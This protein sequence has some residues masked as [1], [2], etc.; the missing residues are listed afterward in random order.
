MNAVDRFVRFK[1]AKGPRAVEQALRYVVMNA[2]RNVPYYQKLWDSSGVI[3]SGIRSLADLPKLPVTSREGLLRAEGQGFLNR[4]ADPGRLFRSSTSGST[5]EPVTVFLNK[6][7]VYF[8]RASLLAALGRNVRLRFPL[9]LVDVGAMRSMGGRD[10]VQSLRIVRVVRLR[11]TMPLQEQA[12]LIRKQRPLVVQGRPSAL[13]L[14]AEELD[15]QGGNPVKPALVVTGAEVLHEPVRA[16]LERS[17]ACRVADYYGSEEIGNIA[18][19]CP[20]N[21]DIMHVNHDTCIVEVVDPHGAPLPTGAEGRVLATNLYNCTMPFIRYDLG[22]QAA[23]VQDRK[24]CRC[25]YSGTSMKLLSGRDD[26]F[27]VLPDGRLASPRFVFQVVWDALPVA[28]LGVRLI[29]SV[30][31]LQI[32]QETVDHMVVRVVPGEE[33]RPELWHSLDDCVRNL[34]PQMN[35][36]VQLVGEPQADRSGKVRQIVSHVTKERPPLGGTKRTTEE[37]KLRGRWTRFR[38]GKSP[39]DV[40]RSLEYVVQEACR[41]VSYY[42]SAWEAAAVN[43]VTIRTS[44]ELPRL[45]MT[46]R[47]SL[48]Q[49]PEPH[50]LHSEADPDRCVHTSTSGIL[51]LPLTIH[52]SRA[53]AMWRK[54]TLLRA[55]G[56]Y[57][58][59]RPPLRLADVGSMVPR[60]GKSMEERLRMVRIARLPATVPPQ[61][62]LSCLKSFRPRI[63]KGYPT[64]LELLAE[65]LSVSKRHNVRPAVVVSGGEV[66]HDATRERLAR[67]FHCPVV[68]LYGCEEGGNLAWECPQR[69]GLWHVN[70]D[71][72]VIEIVDERGA[73]VPEGQEGTV[74]LTNLFNHT[75][76]FIRYQLGDRATAGPVD[77]CTCGA[78]GP[79]LTSIEGRDDDFL[80]APDG[81]RLSPRLVANTVFNTLRESADPSQVSGDV[82]QF[83]IV[84]DGP[85]SVS[86]RVILETPEAMAMA[87]RAAHALQ[88]LVPGIT[89]QV[90][91]VAEIARSPG[92]KLKKVL[93][94]WRP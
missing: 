18:W 11:R 76:P 25:G 89:S 3:I 34:H 94:A 13:A 8:R 45:P 46:T 62:M 82:R 40:N 48:R 49:V 65:E 30:R 81:R 17:F 35:V 71:T 14:L 50:R 66:L 51:G 42:R 6:P 80:I 52:M 84:Q 37:L 93:A 2:Y 57:T 58:G 4:K 70:I 16:L 22:D 64:C 92:G 86:L 56:R 41:S 7:E 15:R 59:T 44:E 87:T 29:K 5:S 36:E 74:L 39:A 20:H 1:L 19:Q 91:E 83:Q 85:H 31:T 9:T 79:S 63:V 24:G 28:E 77:R 26:D 55:M 72:C 68:D 61:E 33:Y 69:P 54:L 38:L 67:A 23:L 47:D 88:A 21:P 60:H 12:S 10:I 43:P 53:E 27:F 78:E 73:P 75:M 90:E 32:V